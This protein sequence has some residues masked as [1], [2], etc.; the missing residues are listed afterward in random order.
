MANSGFLTAGWR[1]WLRNLFSNTCFR[2]TLS[3][4][5]F[6]RLHLDS[7]SFRL[8]VFLGRLTVMPGSR[9]IDSGTQ[10]TFEKRGKLNEASCLDISLC[11]G[12]ECCC[13]GP[14]GCGHVERLDKYC[15]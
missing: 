12:I 15:R 2:L 14:I 8:R 1:A 7:P 10:R 5:S 3:A 11:S 9:E 4:R 6:T 13:C